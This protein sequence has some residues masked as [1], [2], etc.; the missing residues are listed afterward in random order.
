MGHLHMTAEVGEAMGEEI[1]QKGKRTH[2]R[3]GDC[4][5][6]GVIRRLNDNGKNIVKIKYRKIKNPSETLNF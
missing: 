5:G 4:F 6:G 1:E 3:G 2:R